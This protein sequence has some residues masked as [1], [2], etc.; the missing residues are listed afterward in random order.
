[1]SKKT[2]NQFIQPNAKARR[3]FEVWRSL[4]SLEVVSG[5]VLSNFAS[6]DD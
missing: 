5:S 6:A 3:F 4:E 1:V 2:A